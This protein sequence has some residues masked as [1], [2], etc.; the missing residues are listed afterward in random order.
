MININTATIDEL[1][2]IV[3]IGETRATQII[4]RREEK[5]FKDI[6]ELSSMSGFGKSRLDDILKEGKLICE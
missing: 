1:I 5:P 6:Y 2:S 4:A 3:H